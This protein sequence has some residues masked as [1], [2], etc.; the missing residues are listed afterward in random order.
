[1]KSNSSDQFTAMSNRYSSLGLLLILLMTNAVKFGFHELWKDE[2]QAWFVARDMDLWAMLKFLYYEGH[3][4]LWYLYL[5]P[6]TF[7][8]PFVSD[9]III[10]IAHALLHLFFSLVIYRWNGIPPIIKVL[11][12]SGYFFAFEYGVVSR[13]YI[14]VLLLLSYLLHRWSIYNRTDKYFYAGIILLCNTEI[15]GLFAATG[16]SLMIIADSVSNH[17]SLSLLL[18]YHYPLLSA[19]IIGAFTSYI[20]LNWAED[21]GEVRQRLFSI[22]QSMDEKSGWKLT[23]HGLFGNAFLPGIVPDAHRVGVNSLYAWVGV[24]VLLLSIWMLAERKGVMWAYIAVT[25]LNISFAAF[26]YAGGLRQWGLQFCF[27]TI[28]FLYNLSNASPNRL[29]KLIFVMFLLVQIQYTAKAFY[30]DIVYPFTHAKAAGDFIKAKVPENVP[31]VMIDPFHTAAAQGYANRKFYA[32]PDGEEVS[33][34]RWL[35]KVYIPDVNDLRLFASFKG[36]GG[37]I[38]ITHRRLDAGQYPG[39]TL[40]KAFDS[41]SVK[42][43]SYFIYAFKK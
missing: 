37:L 19:L 29:K 26:G 41:F 16:I 20:T 4:S 39:L 1:M 43:E 28:F 21:A 2:W 3:P 5:K 11:L 36:V 7:F 8:T 34:F 33:Y 15:F 12:L 14:L 31:V 9:D 6:F 38:L 24:W 32:L 17:K 35:D 27:F 40:W 10:K 22:M 23:L 25:A 13:G 18:K 42:G 30:K